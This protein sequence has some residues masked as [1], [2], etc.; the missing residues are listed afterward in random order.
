[1]YE[2]YL[3]QEIRSRISQ[4]AGIKNITPSD[5]KHIA[6]EIR[7]TVRKNVSE[8]TLKRFFGF[9]AVSHGF[10]KYTMSALSEYADYMQPIY[11][12]GKPS[13]DPSENSWQKLHKKIGNISDYVLREI[14]N[15]SG[16]PYDLTISRKFAQHDLEEF[17]DNQASFM[18]FIAHPGYGKTILLSHIIQK[19][20]RDQD[21]VY[22]DSIILFLNASSFFRTDNGK[23]DLNHHLKNI[24]SIPQSDDLLIFLKEAN[25]ER[26]KFFLVIDGFEELA[27]NKDSKSQL[28][29][30]LVDFICTLD[31]NHD[32]KIIMSMRSTMWVRFYDK[33]RSSAYLKQ[34]WFKGNYF[35]ENEVS[36][37]PPFTEDELQELVEN[38]GN[39]NY[40]KINP[41]LKAQ[42]KFPFHTQLYY[43]L[44]EEDPFLNYGSNIAF[45]E[46]ISR[47]IQE[48]IFKSNHYTEKL[49]FIKRL[50]EITDY[51]QTSHSVEKNL[52]IEELINFK[53]AYM[54]LVAD[55]ILIE[56]RR[57]VGF[58]PK[59]Y[60][61]FLH[62][63]VF[64]YFIYM[65]L[66]NRFTLSEEVDQIFSY[67][68]SNYKGNANR[69]ILLQWA[70]RHFIRT[71]SYEVIDYIQALQLNNYERNYLVYFI[72]ENLKYE[73]NLF[74]EKANEIKGAKV[75][76]KIIEGLSNLDYIDSCYFEGIQA[77]IDVSD[78]DQNWITYH[79]ILSIIDILSLDTNR[80]SA[81]MDILKQQ[82][83]LCENSFVNP[84][85]FLEFAYAKTQGENPSPAGLIAM[86]E[87]MLA[88]GDK[89]P[90][91]KHPD[92][93]TGVFYMLLL[94]TNRLYGDQEKALQLI[95]VV[96]KVHP[97]LLFSR[98]P[99][100]TYVLLLYGIACARNKQF[101]K[102]LQIK[103]IVTYL[104]KAKDKFGFT[105]Y[106]ESLL[107]YLNAMI[108]KDSGHS[109]QAVAQLF[110][111]LDIFKRNQLNVNSL[112][113]YNILIEIYESIGDL[114]KMNEIKY[115]KRCFQEEKKISKDVIPYTPHPKK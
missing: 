78:I 74:P 69:F 15:R 10:S 110:L 38:T 88:D 111:A 46:L 53:N 70:V 72:A 94:G 20:F 92:T 113:V 8:T 62:P 107:I 105:L 68:D 60:I 108:D 61:S 47:F 67:I 51:G 31:H 17:Y 100:A 112:L 63:Q 66:F 85:V 91:S 29:N 12:G 103:N 35:N 81:R 44:R 98:T 59:E 97:R 83:E 58:F 22:K 24:L 65:E 36:N 73:L 48:K 9:A 27:L 101:K 21:A 37:V 57:S 106:S 82:Q 93:I 19:Y 13:F 32:I 23:F 11:F 71:S 77:L 49:R 42:L 80:L 96:Y 109:D 7:K 114:A 25:T 86:V 56:E 30:D 3:I 40:F 104:A 54:E 64:E 43:Q 28:F 75:H 55:G 95:N 89:L 5:C 1:M 84:L 90:S 50:L 14:R 45:Y 99:F 4:R 6:E 52:L 34:A 18:C 33:I 79:S 102:V 26:N 2:T 16:L 76:E 41:V 115:E 87:N 39:E